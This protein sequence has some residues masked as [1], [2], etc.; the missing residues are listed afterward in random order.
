MSHICVSHDWSPLWH[1]RLNSNSEIWL[2]CGN[3]NEYCVPLRPTFQRCLLPPPLGR[4]VK[5][6][7][8]TA[9]LHRATS[10][11]TVI[12]TI[13][14]LRTWNLTYIGMSIMVW[15]TT[16]TVMLS[17]V[18]MIITLSAKHIYKEDLFGNISECP[19][20]A[21]SG[22]SRRVMASSRDWVS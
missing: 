9:R 15:K 10:Q 8:N 2:S 12:L 20:G 11:K 5:R 22:P 21:D 13:A 14:A 19:R 6:R 1:N 16:H 18:G 4:W 17:S 7:P 3:K